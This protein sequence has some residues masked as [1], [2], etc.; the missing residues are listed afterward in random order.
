MALADCIEKKPI[1]HTERL[2]LR[3]MCA[4]DIPAQKEWMPDK[5][6][7]TYWGNGPG[8]T[9]IRIQ[10][11]FLKKQKSHQRAFISELN[12]MRFIRLWGNKGD[13]TEA[14]DTMVRFCFDNTELKRIWTDR[15]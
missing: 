14:M 2:S 3:M 6:I 15:E 9:G 10:N 8:K 11:C 4:D 1:I 5:A 12:L 13:A 7:H